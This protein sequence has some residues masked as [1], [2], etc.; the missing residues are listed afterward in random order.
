MQNQTGIEASV[1][2]ISS[3]N[4]NLR[5]TTSVKVRPVGKLLLLH[6]VARATWFATSIRDSHELPEYCQSEIAKYGYTFTLAAV[7]DVFGAP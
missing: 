2:T 5:S 7:C 4:S 6:L 3:C 1:E